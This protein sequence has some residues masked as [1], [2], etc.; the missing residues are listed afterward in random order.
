MY[1]KALV[2]F[3]GAKQKTVSPSKMVAALGTDA[4]ASKHAWFLKSLGFTLLAN[5]DGRAVV[6]YTML[7]APKN[8]PAVKA[9]ATAKTPKAAKPSAPKVKTA[10]AVATAAAKKTK[11][12]PTARKANVT[13]ATTE[14]FDDDVM[15]DINQLDDRS[16]LPE[17]MR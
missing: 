3:D 4:P 11:K 1:T 12:S 13:A 14:P 6:S 5:K 9:T 2:L 8:P 16:D 7:S 10:P 17:F 15:E